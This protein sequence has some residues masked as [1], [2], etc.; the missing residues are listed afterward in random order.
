MAKS[1]ESNTEFELDE[2]LPESQQE[3]GFVAP[4]T[5]HN[6]T[7]VPQKIGRFRVAM[8]LGEGGFGQ[9]FKAFDDQLERWV[10]IKIPRLHLLTSPDA[11]EKY[12]D[13]A[14][15]LAKLEHPAIVQ[16][17]DVGKTDNGL[18]YIVSNY[19]DGTSLAESIRTR[20]LT[21][22]AGIRVLITIGE[23]LAYIHDKGILHRDVK[24][25]NIL[26]SQADRPF[27]A[28]FGLAIADE[29][30]GF[31]RRQV[32]TLAYMSPEQA[33]G[34]AHLM[35]GRADIY[36]LGVVMFQMLTGKLP[37]YANNR[38]DRL[39]A[40]ADREAISLRQLNHKV[41]RELERICIKA[42]A[43]RPSD[44]YSSA[45][46]LIE[47][48]EYFIK[49]EPHESS[50]S[51]SSIPSR[52]TKAISKD[53]QAIVPRG[54]RSF[55]RHDASFFSQLLPGPY[56]RDWIPESLLF[57]QRRLLGNEAEESFR[58]GVLYGPSGCG[59]SS[60]A[61]AGLIPLVQDQVQAVFAE[62]T[63]NETEARILRSVRQKFPQLSV[64]HGLVESLSEIRRN[65]AAS[66]GKK[67]F[68]VIDQFEQWLNGRA[69]QENLELALALRQCDG[70]NVQC[71]ILI[72]DDFWLAMSRFASI[73]EVSLRQNQ[74]LM[75]VDLFTKSH[76]RQVLKLLGIAYGCLPDN[77]NLTPAQESFLEQAVD[78]LSDEGR[79]IPI[80][81]SLFC[82]MVK[83]Q[84]WDTNT[85]ARLG[86]VKGIGTRFLEES[87][88]SS[89][90]PASHRIHEMAA[91][92]VLRLLLPDHGGN[93]KG[94]MQ[95]EPILRSAAGYDDQPVAF[96]ELIDILDGELRLIT[97]TDPIGSLSLEE[98]RSQSFSSDGMRYYQLTHDFLVPEL[99]GWLHKKQRESGE[100]RAQLRL[101]EYANLWS[102]KPIA[103]FA[104][105]WLEWL[106][107]RWLSS[108]RSWNETEKQMMRFAGA[109]HLRNSLLIG[110][111]LLIALSAGY[112]M[113]NQSRVSRLV[114]QLRLAQDSQIGSLINQLRSD[115]RTARG[116]LKAALSNAPEE[117]AE[118]RLRLG[119]LD[120]DPTQAQW[121]E[122]RVLQEP[123][124]MVRVICEQFNATET[125][126]NLKFIRLLDNVET[127]AEQ[128]LRAALILASYVR[129]S[130]SKNSEELLS[131]AAESL[132]AIKKQASVLVDAT[133]QHL[134][135]AP[136][137]YVYV[138]EGL[139]P[140]Q[141]LLRDE[142]ARLA[143]TD[144]ATPR[145]SN[146]TALLV[147][148]CKSDPATLL[149][150]AT[151]ASV[152]Q[153]ATFME[154]LERQL[155]GLK[156]ELTQLAFEEIDSTI[157][158]IQFDRR[159]MA[160]A[161]AAALLHRV[162]TDTA[163]WPM[164]KMSPMPH[165][166]SYLIDRLS[167]LS[168]HV[169]SLINRLAREPDASA[170][171]GLILALGHYEWTKQEAAL[172]TQVISVCREM[173][174]D[175]PKVCVHSAARWFLRRIG[176]SAWVDVELA[177]L[178]T[179]SSDPRKDWHVNSE[180]FTM[181]IIDAR[182]VSGIGR[183]YEIATMEVAVDQFLRFRPEFNYY[184]DRSPTVDCP[185][186]SCTWYD[187]AAY[188]HWL[189]S[190]IDPSE[191]FAESYPA[192]LAP[193]N[194]KDEQELEQA[195]RSGAYRL[196][197]S[198]E[199]HYAC[200]GLTQSIRYFGIGDSIFDQW[201]FY[202]ETSVD[203]KTGLGRYWPGD[204]LHPNGL[205]LFACY[206]G[207]REWAH[208]LNST[209]N[210]AV[211]GFGNH[212]D[213][214]MISD[215]RLEAGD[216]PV[217]RNGYYGLRIARTVVS[218]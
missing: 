60:F 128:R 99:Y 73:L 187:A 96:S 50:V 190:K 74:N 43:K 195:I 82:E 125:K 90:A 14:R 77:Q 215:A 158:E 211:M 139:A 122:D 51:S 88:S 81:L 114:D 146:A 132:Q 124:P 19:V 111:V 2:L 170:R 76:A 123:I 28:D 149:S 174:K 208:D 20:E 105:S 75:L 164:L 206:D 40:T 62:A 192:D 168:S 154:E 46:R 156:S 199:W 54:L 216:L 23:A 130:E 58:V 131:S 165:A 157:D 167:R 162:G 204:R 47:D 109:R 184:R 121:L 175:D 24:P 71:L 179:L 217:V 113:L 11:L 171:Q 86:G 173:F 30:V 180:G 134:A 136:Q 212:A 101:A 116:V 117:P 32:G 108:P 63:S 44:R 104:P 186:G 69:E 95:P 214:A 106:T 137:D 39:S 70:L 145:R 181:A 3:G 72:R 36:S 202:W 193:G 18:P 41:P 26:L 48:L 27:L 80:R 144:Q 142:L 91:R 176:E 161:T 166:R 182:D 5:V 85:L 92:N 12:L 141:E 1:K 201:S 35:D 57:W 205:G 183:V 55:E 64:E 203:S 17:H 218:E 34:E 16:V 172:R 29:I 143:L 78:E 31:D 61:K 110:I 8:L 115:Q 68:I 9:V 66:G 38:N 22:R 126:L 140:I 213:K 198:F 177:R 4:T 112:W 100:G 59:K 178:S 200:R 107:I 120:S 118:L 150:T 79:V 135:A 37:N 83:S 163:A 148:Y 103:K 133:L 45:Q 197:T 152:E 65:R 84:P 7:D 151:Q 127:D 207:I 194:A 189:S 119:L 129:E 15:T 87:F 33:R 209:D 89:L 191:R 10:A 210:R 52:T 102:S 53:V 67:L 13:E 56:S 155:P 147:A 160:S 93:L 97:P 188:C 98:S 138:Q 42:L 49:S 6:F 25:A 159:S 94:K 196:P 185:M 169:E 21:L 153:Y